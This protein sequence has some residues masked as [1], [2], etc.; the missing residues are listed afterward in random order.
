MIQKY[1]VWLQTRKID[2]TVVSFDWNTFS[3]V[4]FRR[5]APNK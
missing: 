4:G 1:V 5:V 2:S 3:T